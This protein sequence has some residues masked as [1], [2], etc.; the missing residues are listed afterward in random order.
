MT[1]LETHTRKMATWNQLTNEQAIERKANAA[2]VDA[3]NTEKKRKKRRRK[4]IGM[5]GKKKEGQ[6]AEQDRPLVCIKGDVKKGSKV[7]PEMVVLPNIF[8]VLVRTG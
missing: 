6:N 4:R 1:R 8:F 2:E 7:A 3:K 5:K